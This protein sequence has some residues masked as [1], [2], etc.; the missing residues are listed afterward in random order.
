MNEFLMMSFAF[1]QMY[2]MFNISFKIDYTSKSQKINYEKHPEVTPSK[3]YAQKNFF[4]A[5]AK[6]SKLIKGNRY[7]N[8][9][10]R[11]RRLFSKLEQKTLK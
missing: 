2:K 7:G 3:G 10:N 11:K 8:H 9:L 4:P 1:S 6:T 5:Y